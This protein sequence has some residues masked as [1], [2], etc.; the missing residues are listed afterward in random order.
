MKYLA[1]FFFIFSAK[2]YTVTSTQ[3]AVPTPTQSPAVVSSHPKGYLTAAEVYKKV[4]E[5]RS[6]FACES[7][8]DKEAAPRQFNAN[9]SILW[10]NDPKTGKP[11]MRD[12]GE[13]QINTWV[14]GKDAAALGLDLK[15]SENDN[16]YFGYVLYE[17]YGLSPWNPSKS[18]WG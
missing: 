13:A 14:W 3:L 18:C 12:V 16:V 5:L 8:G 9:G 17:K 11:I 7:A 1:F 10:G 4:P 15:N 2:A 6:I